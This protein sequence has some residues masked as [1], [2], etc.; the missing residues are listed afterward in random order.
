MNDMY[1]IDETD[2]VS[3]FEGIISLAIDYGAKDRTT[4]VRWIIDGETDI[5]YV[6]YLY[7][8]PIGYLKE[9]H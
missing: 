4:A 2:M 8:L 6:E 5:G 3:N 1:M 9:Y 7:D